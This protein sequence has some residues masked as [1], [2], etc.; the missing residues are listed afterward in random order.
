MRLVINA[1]VT[2]WEARFHRAEC[3]F[4]KYRKGRKN[5]KPF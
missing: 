5:I 1:L 2:L 3:K 4:S